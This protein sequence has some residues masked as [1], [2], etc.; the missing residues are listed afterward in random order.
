MYVNR[1]D[2][3]W[4]DL[5]TEDLLEHL[6][7]T[8]RV[9]GDRD[10]RAIMGVSMGGM[11]A[12]RIALT[13]PELFCAVGAHSSA[14]FPEDPDDLPERLKSFAKQLGLIDE[15]GN[16]VG[17]IGQY[18]HFSRGVFSSAVLVLPGTAGLKERLP[19]LFREGQGIIAN[20][21]LDAKG[22]FVAQEVLAK[23]DENYMPPELAGM[24]KKDGEQAEDPY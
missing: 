9:S 16:D 7:E 15:E 2:E 4:Q 6:S 12:L 3:K 23:H 20:G 24:H 17:F 21:K 18:G 10:Q 5:V 22:N 13:R 8:Y 14:V 19:D 11:A 1:K